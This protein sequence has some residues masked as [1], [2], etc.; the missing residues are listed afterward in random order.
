MQQSIIK[1]TED[2]KRIVCEHYNVSES[3]INSKSRESHIVM[4]RQVYWYMV[5][6]K[7]YKKR[8]RTKEY[9][10][11]FGYSRANI[12]HGISKVTDIASINKDF[13]NNLCALLEKVNSYIFDLRDFNRTD[14]SILLLG[15]I[16]SAI[17]TQDTQTAK[18]KAIQLLTAIEKLKTNEAK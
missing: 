2:I 6:L 18:I 7:S 15:E 1:E 8:I 12:D 14:E 17:E 4:A 9:E 11:L 10:Q 13:D 3:E 5:K 16:K